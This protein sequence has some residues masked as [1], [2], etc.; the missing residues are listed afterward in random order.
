MT[1]AFTTKSVAGDSGRGQAWTAEEN[2]ILA[3]IL[4][5]HS[6][7]DKKEAKKWVC[8]LQDVGN[9]GRTLLAIQDHLTE[10][11]RYVSTAVMTSSKDVQDPGPPSAA[12]RREDQAEASF[13]SHIS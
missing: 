8:V 7:Y 2:N 4:L 13:S 9:K 1:E 12:V 10:M 11:L 3:D 6:C 5:K